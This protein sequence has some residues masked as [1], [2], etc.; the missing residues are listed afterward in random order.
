MDLPYFLYMAEAEGQDYLVDTRQARLNAVGADLIN[1]GY[2]GKVVPGAVFQ[3]LL[4]KHKINDI[5]Q[6]EIEYIERTWI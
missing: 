2:R 1:M 3:S 4:I 6:D 5:T